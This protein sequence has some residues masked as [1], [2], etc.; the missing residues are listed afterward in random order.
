MFVGMLPEWYPWPMRLERRFAESGYG[1]ARRRLAVL[2]ALLVAVLVLAPAPVAAQTEIEYSEPEEVKPTEDPDRRE[3]EVRMKITARNPLEAVQDRIHATARLVP[4]FP[5]TNPRFSGPSGWPDTVTLAGVK[6]ELRI[7]A[8]DGAIGRN[9]KSF[10]DARRG[11]RIAAFYALPGTN[12]NAG[13][14]PRYSWDERGRL[15]Q[16]IWYEPK[17]DRLITYDYTYYKDGRLLGYS[18][19]DGPRE[20]NKGSYDEFLSQFYDRNGKLIAVGYEKKVGDAS[21]SAYTWNGQPIEFDDFRMKSHVLF[22]A[23][24][25]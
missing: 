3:K 18:W 23:A 10:R 24:R 7:Q 21:V 9:I 14:G 11:E 19:R 1:P 4:P 15:T 6:M 20:S 12:L 16:R 25:K 8:W 5:V 17:K 13:W 22:T 2:G